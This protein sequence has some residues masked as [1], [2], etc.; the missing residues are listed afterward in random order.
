MAQVNELFP[1]YVFKYGPTG[2]MAVWLF[3]MNSRLSDVEQRLYK[4]LETRAKIETVI[5]QTPPNSQNGNLTYFQTAAIRPD[6][7]KV[8]NKKQAM[9][10]QTTD[11]NL[12]YTQNAAEN[13]ART[14]SDRKVVEVNTEVSQP[15]APKKEEVKDVPTKTT[16]NLDAMTKAE[17]LT[18]ADSLF[19][20]INKRA[21]KQEIIEVIQTAS[22]S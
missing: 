18:I 4:C 22:N 15:T 10:Y 16:T 7:V 17:L 19:I 8:K 13:H 2:I 6:D 3:T 5:E 21:N 20:E 11:G 14:L 12:F 9:Y 1:E